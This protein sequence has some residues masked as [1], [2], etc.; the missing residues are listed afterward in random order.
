MSEQA[1]IDAQ[2]DELVRKLEACDMPHVNQAERPVAI[3]LVTRYNEALL[4]ASTPM[5][6][7]TAA[8]VIDEDWR[9]RRIHH[10]GDERD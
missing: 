9:Q 8:I 7:E 4:A 2:V 5:E 10:D 1:P 3:R 6:L